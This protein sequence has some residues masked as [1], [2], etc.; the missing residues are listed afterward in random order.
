MP[1]DVV[2]AVHR[3]AVTSKQTGGITFTNK[4]GNIITEDDESEDKNEP[5]YIPIPPDDDDHDMQTERDDISQETTGVDDTQDT[6]NMETE[7]ET[8]A[9]NVET[10]GVDYNDMTRAEYIQENNISTPNEENEPNNYVFVADINITSEL[11]TS[12]RESDV[13]EEESEGRT[14]AR[15]NLHPKPRNM[16]Q[17]TMAQSTEDSITLPK[18]QTYI[19]MMQLNVQ[20]GLKA[21]GKKGDE[22]IMKEI[23]QLHTRKALLPCNRNG[24]T[25]DERKKALRYLMFLKEKRDRSIKARGCA[26]GIPQHIY[27]NKEEASSPTMSIEAMVL[28]CAIDA[29]EIDT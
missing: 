23:A 7:M 20:E 16:M 10:A 6:E 18:T 12:N 27:T 19:M 15:Y 5:E 8:E 25:Y 1:N 22:A 24:M 21:Y 28:S 11:N 13:T 4:A 17:Y 26:D 14:N 3:L 2:D 29:K 9:E